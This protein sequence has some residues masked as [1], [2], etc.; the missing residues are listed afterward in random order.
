MFIKYPKQVGFIINKFK[1]AGY[2][3]YIV[4]GCVRDSL[5]KLE[6]KDWDITTN[7]TP[8]QIKELFK[9]FTILPTGEKYG[10]I[11]LLL[12]SKDKI[13][14]YEITTF[15]A[16]GVY[17]DGRRPESVTFGTNINEDLARRDFTINA[18]A[19][20]RKL[21][22]PFSG[23]KDLRNKLIKTVGNPNKRFDEDR[24]RILRGIRF[25]CKYNFRIERKT[26]RA[27]NRKYV[28]ILE[29][30]SKERI[31]DELIKILEYADDRNYNQLHKL[32]NLWNLI[33]N[34][35]INICAEIT[36]NKPVS[37]KLFK[38]FKRI[39][40]DYLDIEN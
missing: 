40:L 9:G 1:N 15:R 23:V 20:D 3:A 4:G 7:A 32:A 29:K 10:T 22:D 35:E 6:P 25:V 14:S 17:S 38:I 18:M 39:G 26:S 2:E 19:Y 34:C 5:L 21:V 13:D 36:L 30:I 37:Y 24:L 16:D 27:M 11:T 12:Y 33:F 31:H 28:D 8:D